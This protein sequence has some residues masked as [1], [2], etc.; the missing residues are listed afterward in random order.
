VDIEALGIAVVPD[1]KS[2]LQ[3][4]SACRR[5]STS[6][7]VAGCAAIHSWN[8]GEPATGPP[9]IVIVATGESPAAANGASAFGQSSASTIAVVAPTWSIA[10]VRTSGASSGLTGTATSPAFAIPKSVSTASTEF[11]Q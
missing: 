3:T 4:S 1:V 10:Q 7:S 9:P 5:G 11:S 8:D 2:T 6:G